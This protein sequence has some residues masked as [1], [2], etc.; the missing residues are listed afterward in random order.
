ML[1]RSND[2]IRCNLF[3]LFNL[4]CSAWISVVACFDRPWVSP[5]RRLCLFFKLISEVYQRSLFGWS[6]LRIHL[7]LLHIEVCFRFRLG[8]W[9][10][11]ICRVPLSSP[12]TAARRSGPTDPI[13]RS[14]EW[15]LMKF[16]TDIYGIWQLW[17][18]YSTVLVSVLATRSTVLYKLSE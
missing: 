2:L 3:I 16:D 8:W 10:W 13:F 12:A 4:L 1:H 15:R 11:I 18:V 9:W 5:L 6:R 17:W 14:D 7:Y